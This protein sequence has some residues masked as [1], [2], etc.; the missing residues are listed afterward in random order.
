[1]T[2]VALH[3]KAFDTR[4]QKRGR[5]PAAG[6]NRRAVV[7]WTRADLVRGFDSESYAE[8]DTV[9]IWPNPTRLRTD[10]QMQEWAGSLGIVTEVFV[11]IDLDPG[12]PNNCYYATRLTDADAMV[13]IVKPWGPEKCFRFDELEFVRAELPIMRRLPRPERSPFRDYW[14]SRDDE[15]NGIEREDDT[16]DGAPRA[17][18]HHGKT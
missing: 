2:Y 18:L 5:L 1:M 7:D 8:G 3:K 17:S 11:P 12:D 6:W 13:Q 14:L 10:P 15:D 9:R 4:R 16:N